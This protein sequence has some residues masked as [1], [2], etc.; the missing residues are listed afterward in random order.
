M[1]GL[2]SKRTKRFVE[3]FISWEQGINLVLGKTGS[4]RKH[5]LDFSGMRHFIPIKQLETSIQDGLDKLEVIMH[6][7]QCPGAWTNFE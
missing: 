7:L 1:Y 4:K 5:S 2:T 3:H 6:V